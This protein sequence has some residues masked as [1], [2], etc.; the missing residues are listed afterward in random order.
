MS[1]ELGE[2]VKPPMTEPEIRDF[3]TENNY[4]VGNRVMSRCIDGRYPSDESLPALAIPG[5]DIGQMVMLFATANRM[6]QKLNIDLAFKAL[7]EVVGGVENIRIHTDDSDHSDQT[8]IAD[9]CGYFKYI[10]ENPEKF[11]VKGELIKALKIKF[12]EL[13]NKGAKQEV[14]SGK[15]EEQAA[16]IIRGDMGIKPDGKFF[17]FHETLVDE[18]SKK[19]VDRLFELKAIE[20]LNYENGLIEKNKQHFMST[21]REVTQMHLSLT[22]EKLAKGKPIFEVDFSQ[23]SEFTPQQKGSF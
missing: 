5:A 15:H 9:G 19:L 14:L 21:L 17:V 3:I 4:P 22:G 10:S 6:G 2:S 13:L 20:G 11:G 8:K 23:G 12:E 18:R 7:I 1:D 16:L